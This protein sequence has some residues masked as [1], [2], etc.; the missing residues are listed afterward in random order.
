MSSV[1]KRIVEMEFKNASFENGV[2][3]SMSTLERLK[4]ALKLGG[5]SKGL[6]DIDK[7]SKNC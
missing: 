4:N 7:A 6:E 3:Q 1:D 5:A 2:R